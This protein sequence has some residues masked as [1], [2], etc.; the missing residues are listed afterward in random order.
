MSLSLQPRRFINSEHMGKTTELNMPFGKNDAEIC[1]KIHYIEEGTGEP[2]ILVHSAGQSLYTWS[3]VIEPLSAKFRVIA[4]DLLGHGYSDVPQYCD[5]DIAQQAEVL[6]A[7]MKKLGISSAHFVGF[8]L[9]CAIIAELA[10]EHPT[11]VG[12]TIMLS[13]GGITPLM[14]SLVRMLGSRFLGAVASAFITKKAVTGMLSECFLDLT[15]VDSSKIEQ[16]FKP[17]DDPDTKRGTRYLVSSF[18]EDEFMGALSSIESP[19]LLLLAADDKWRTVEFIQPYFDILKNGSS[20]V[21]RNAGHLMHEDQPAKVV[22]SIIAFINP[23]TAEEEKV[24][25]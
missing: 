14:P 2:L 1:V 3:N 10:R 9:G 21:V 8:S 19:I 23:T 22:D 7:F 17:L 4:L 20:D 12:R 18:N 25:E 11:K 15:K 13:P 5:F 6:S 24:T 16:Y